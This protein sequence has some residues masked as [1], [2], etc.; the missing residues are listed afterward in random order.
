MTSTPNPGSREA[1]ARGCQCPVIDNG[2]GKGYMGGMKD[3]ETGETVFV[4]TVGCPVHTPH[5]E[6]RELHK[7]HINPEG[8]AK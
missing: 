1:R 2:H 5:D 8:V 4:I 7:V 3:R 6:W